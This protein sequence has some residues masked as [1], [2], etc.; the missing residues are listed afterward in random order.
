MERLQRVGVRTGPTFAA[1]APASTS[2]LPKPTFQPGS[3]IYEM[4][5]SG[6]LHRFQCGRVLGRGGFAKCYEVSDETGTY[7]LKAVNRASLEKPKTLQKLHSEISIHRRMKHKHVVEFLR[8][9][10]DRY[11]VYMLLEKCDHGTLMDLL[12]VRR[13]SVAET[14]YVMLQC[15]SAL[16]YMHSECVIHRDL[17]PGNIMLDRELNVKIGDF[18]LAAE[19][20][21]DGERKRTICGTPNYI[22][23]EI[24]DHK[25]HGHSYEVDTWSLGV[26]LYTLL[27]GQP[28]FQMED[29]ESTYKRIRQCRY[30]FPANVPD[31]ARDLITQILQS[32]PAH[33]PT[34]MDIRQH[35]FFS[36]SPPPPLTP[37]ASFASF[38]L[39]VP[40]PAAPATTTTASAAAATI[41]TRSARRA[42]AVDM[43]YPPPAPYGKEL[44]GA[45][46]QREVLRPINANVP[47][48]PG[49]PTSPRHLAN[50]RQ[51]QQPAPAPT[52]PGICAHARNETPR[53]APGTA[54]VPLSGRCP[55]SS[56]QQLRNDAN[57]DED[58]K[59]QLTALHDRLHQ[60]LCG[61]AAADDAADNEAPPPPVWVTQCADFSS[62]YG[63]AYRLSTGQ[64][65]AHFN[66]STKIVWEPITDRVEYHARVKIEM[67]ARDGSTGLFA[68]DERHV[69]SMHNYPPELEKKVTLTKYFKTYLGR[70]QSSPD[71]VPVVACSPFLPA[72]PPRCTDPHTSSDFV[73]V[74]RWL[75]VDGALVFR[76]SNKT[77]QVCFE[78]G[79]EI[80]LSSEWR[81]VTYTT[82]SGRRRTMPLNSVATEW[83]EA[84][85][86]LRNTKSVLYQVIRD[87]CL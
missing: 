73:Y 24:I 43:H 86:R 42:S 20:Q 62:K 23:P 60:T 31:N 49:A 14:Q 54:A 38:G 78:D 71:K 37:P 65:G 11:Y 75:R 61:D 30:D 74:K 58:E 36:S 25:S 27:V 45:P 52:L 33:R 35:S 56:P 4:D 28:P 10:R 68:K 72:A 64:T 32:S 69:F 77:V 79:A 26:I 76:L 5:S 87:H 46:A 41:T 59:Q 63:M 44:L 47:P 22:A 40:G 83:E 9:F 13:F 8:T 85:E 84:A 2:E 82:P 48:P 57:A 16:Q 18:G 67:P 34:L 29:V 12:K 21:Y 39:P 66:D 80:I 6:R 81:V 19:L 15:L 1:D 70:V 7:A 51:Q 50:L 53:S 3:S 17:K 55:A